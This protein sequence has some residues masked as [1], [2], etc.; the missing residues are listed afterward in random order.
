MGD[1]WV[2]AAFVVLVSNEMAEVS[3]GWTSRFAGFGCWNAVLNPSTR[4]LRIAAEVVVQGSVLLDKNH[5]MLDVRQFGTG[6]RQKEPSRTSRAATTTNNPRDVS[7]AMVA[8]AQPSSAL[9]E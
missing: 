6:G 3:H 2:H 5:H 9:G 8:A 7:S 4:G 1:S